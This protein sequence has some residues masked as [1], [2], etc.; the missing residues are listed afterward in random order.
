M[1]DYVTGVKTSDGV[2][3]IDYN[4]LANKP[5]IVTAEEDGLM[6][7]GDKV[8]FDEICEDVKELQ[9]AVD[10]VD[11]DIEDIRQDITDV[12]QA[13]E[14][15]QQTVNQA[16]EEK[17]PLEH[18]HNA[19][20]IIDGVFT[21]DRLPIIPIKNGGTDASTPIDAAKN[22]SVPTLLQGEKIS[23]G[24]DLNTYWSIGTYHGNNID[25]DMLHCPVNGPFKLHIYYAD[26]PYRISQTVVQEITDL[27]NGTH[28][29]R[30]GITSS[31]E[32]NAWTTPP[33]SMGDILNAT[34]KYLWGKS[35]VAGTANIAFGD[36]VNVV[37][38]KFGPTFKNTPCVFVS[39]VFDS[40]NII[41]R[42]DEI[43]TTGFR[44]RVQGGFEKTGTRDF[45]WVAIGQP[46][47]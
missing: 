30:S 38:V 3:K 16:I 7:A 21:V 14:N 11:A 28:I 32:W 15:A 39:Q 9:D 10:Q 41:V 43:T 12:Q 13:V 34:Q 42:H 5:G 23:N 44:A 6:S 18:K 45:F 36:N 27:V 37:D 2:K 1:A 22:L 33:P 8:K 26:D 47:D 24:S 25:L 4:A 17:A 31:G 40:A 29:I 35:I 19:D 20:E 46:L